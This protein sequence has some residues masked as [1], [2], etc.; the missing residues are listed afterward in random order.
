MSTA[1]NE[2]VPA[3]LLLSFRQILHAMTV[4]LNYASL[5]IIFPSVDTEALP[6]S[7]LLNIHNTKNSYRMRWP[8]KTR[9]SHELK[10]V[11]PGKVILMKQKGRRESVVA[12]RYAFN[13]DRTLSQS[14]HFQV[15][16][17]TGVE[18]EHHL[19]MKGWSKA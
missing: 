18:E 7:G 4:V 13:E 9:D 6:V 3:Q 19:Y 12:Y 15:L 10:T 1:I 5:I 17:K 11:A 14:S 2:F 16:E 8:R